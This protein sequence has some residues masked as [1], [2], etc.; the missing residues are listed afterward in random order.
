MYLISFKW[1]KAN[2]EGRDHDYDFRKT[3]CLF[4]HDYEEVFTT[5][6]QTRKKYMYHPCKEKY[7]PVLETCEKV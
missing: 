2:C 6:P 5:D 4:L 3:R 7:C 1:F